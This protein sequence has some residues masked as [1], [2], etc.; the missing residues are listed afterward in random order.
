MLSIDVSENLTKPAVGPRAMDVITALH[1]ADQ[2]RLDIVIA[3]ERGEKNDVASESSAGECT[4]RSEVRRWPDALFAL[5][6]AFDFLRI[7]ADMLADGGDL[8]DEHDRGGQKSVEGV[9]GHL[10]GFDGHPFD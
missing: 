1:A 2:L 8:V 6:A 4:A 3:P 7:R 5:Q 10:R 9:L